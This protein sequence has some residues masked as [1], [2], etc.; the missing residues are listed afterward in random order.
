MRRYEPVEHTADVGIKAYGRDLAELFSNAGFGMFDIIAELKFFK[1]QE[2]FEI[3][4]KEENLEELLVSWLRE[5]LGK[6]IFNESVVVNTEIK[7]ISENKLKAIIFCDRITDK[8]KIKKDIK[9]VTYHDLHIKKKN[10]H[11]ETQIIFDV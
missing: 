2:K 4:L 5:L 10:N 3:N 1:P 6:Y 11:Y 9:A 7:E 8:S